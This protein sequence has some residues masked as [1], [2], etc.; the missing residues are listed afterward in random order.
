MLPIGLLISFSVFALL[1]L[2]CLLGGVV[3][4]KK[5]KTLY[6]FL[7]LA[8]VISSWMTLFW[9]VD[10]IKYNTHM[11]IYKGSPSYEMSITERNVKTTIYNS[12]G[13]IIDVV[14]SVVKDTTLVPTN[15]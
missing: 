1:S 12:K 5:D 3:Y 15:H 14:E 6:P 11:E 2:A 9:S 10:Q 13:E 4:I 8:L 7:V